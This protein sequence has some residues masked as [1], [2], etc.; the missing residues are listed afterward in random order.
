VIAAFCNEVVTAEGTASRVHKP[1]G[2]VQPFRLKN[3]LFVGISR[4]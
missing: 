3:C 4:W 1:L 2:L